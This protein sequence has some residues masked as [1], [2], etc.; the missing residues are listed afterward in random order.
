[1]K[2]DTLQIRWQRASSAAAELDSAFTLQTQLSR[3]QSRLLSL[4][5]RR[6][7]LAIKASF[8]GYVSEW[9]SLSK[10]DYVNG[11]SPLVTLYD[12][13]SLVVKAYVEG[14]IVPLLKEGSRVDFIGNDGEQLSAQLIIDKVLP[15]AIKRLDYPGLGSTYGGAIATQKLDDQLIPEEATYEVQL[16]LIGE[17]PLMRQQFGQVN[18]AVEPHS[19]LVDGLRRIYGVFIRESG[20]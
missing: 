11:Q 17:A 16:K 18:L 7:K 9:L 8:D 19:L 4:L 3:E 6:E 5:E 20:F 1:M 13:G 14:R 10:G 15:T 2:L 12:D